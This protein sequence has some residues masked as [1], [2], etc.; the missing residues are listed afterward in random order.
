MA[1]IRHWSRRGYRS[2]L[3]RTQRS[4]INVESLTYTS[5]GQNFCSDNSQPRS[6]HLNPFDSWFDKNFARL[7]RI[8]AEV[9]ITRGQSRDSHA[10]CQTPRCISGSKVVCFVRTSV[11][12]RVADVLFRFSAAVKTTMAVIVCREFYTQNSLNY[13]PTLGE[14]NRQHQE[15]VSAS[16]A[17]LFIQ[18]SNRLE[19]DRTSYSGC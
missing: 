3:P 15:T 7:C 12:H 6:N 4:S 1:L 10:H 14:Y 8:S 16:T 19:N 13:E 2:I 5:E 9:T 18:N 11:R 17:S